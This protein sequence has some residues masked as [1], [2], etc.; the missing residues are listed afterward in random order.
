[1]SNSNEFLTL[2]P[3]R[4]RFATRWLAENDADL[5]RVFE[6]YGY[7]KLW[8]RPP[9]FSTMVHI[10]LEQQ[11]SLASAN[12]TFGRLTSKLDG[13][14]TAERFLTLTEADLKELS[15]TRQKTLYTRLLAEQVASG[16]FSLDALEVLPDDLVRESL[17]KHKGIGNWTADIYLSECLL[18]CDILP[19]G[20]V[21]VQEAIRVL[22]GLE[23]R[24]SHESL[25]AITDHW[26]PWRSVGTRMLW[27]FYLNRL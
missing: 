3:A 22:K 24:P 6:A 12:A 20:D 15:F 9:G 19:R 23:Q 2:T 10:I 25:E 21:G 16:D 14:V 18:R 27:Q 11:V 5:K 26:R 8:N 4:L 13:T 17:T 7:P 1:M